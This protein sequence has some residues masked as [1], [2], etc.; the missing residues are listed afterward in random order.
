[1]PPPP[2]PLEIVHQLEAADPFDPRCGTNTGVES[3]RETGW[4]M[5]IAVRAF[6]EAM[7]KIPVR[8]EEFVFVDIG[9]GKGRGVMLAS[10]YPFKR[11]IGVELDPEWHAIAQQNLSKWHQPTQRCTSLEV[12]CANALTFEYP[13]EDLFLFYYNAFSAKKLEGLLADLKKS[14]AEHP[15][16]VVML[17]ATH[18]DDATVIESGLLHR[19]GPQ[20]DEIHRWGP[21]GKRPMAPYP[22][23][24][25]KYPY[26]VYSNFD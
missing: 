22:M 17:Y 12:V 5:A 2:S 19:W 24:E 20:G 21:R 9:S 3:P 14:V 7:R 6:D 11:C 4:H 16:R 1:D 23:F 10:E 15:R 25:G 26:A 13:R 18:E 8:H